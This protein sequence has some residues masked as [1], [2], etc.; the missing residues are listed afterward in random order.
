MDNKGNATGKNPNKLIQSI[1]ATA[2]MALI[3][4]RAALQAG[5]SQKEADR[6]SHEYMKVLVF[7]RNEKDFFTPEEIKA[8]KKILEDAKKGGDDRG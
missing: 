3:F 5:A 1:G 6:L 2:E 8:I 4:R 7:G